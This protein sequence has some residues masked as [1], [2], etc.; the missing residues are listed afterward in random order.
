MSRRARILGLGIALAQSALAIEQAPGGNPSAGKGDPL[1]EVTIKAQRELAGKLSKFVYQIAGTENAEGLPRWN[2]PVCPLVTGLSRDEGELILA[3]ISEVARAA[4]VPLAGESCRPN[5]YVVVL[6]DPKKALEE[7]D[8]HQRMIIFGQTNENL[9]RGFIDTPRAVR[10][11]YNSDMTDPF[12]MPPGI[13]SD[14]GMGTL[15]ALFC[16]K[17][18]FEHTL[19]THLTYNRIWN[20]TRVVLV[21]DRARLEGI[22]PRQLAGYIAMVGLAEIRPYAHLD[23]DPTILRLFYSAAGTAPADMTAWDQGFLKS[24]YATEQKSMGQ[25]GEIAY[26]MAREMTHR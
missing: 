25:R 21:V 2:M 3:R 6:E 24:L 16:D 17:P 5:L 26:T 15:N 7:L 4:Q 14:C 1:G 10:V 23:D 22:S 11:W 12:G 8:V 19:P 9:I 20:F 18:V 13:F